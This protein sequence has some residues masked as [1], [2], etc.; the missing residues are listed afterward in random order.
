MPTGAVPNTLSSPIELRC[1]RSE[2]CDDAGAVANGLSPP[3]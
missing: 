2:R 3:A 1:E